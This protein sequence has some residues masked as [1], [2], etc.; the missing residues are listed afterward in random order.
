MMPAPGRPRPRS[1]FLRSLLPRLPFERQP[2]D[3]GVALLMVIM[4]MLVATALSVLLMGLVIA[5]RNPT[6]MQRKYAQTVHG[7]EAGIGAGLNQIRAATT[8]NA[9]GVSQGDRSKLPCGPLTG[10][11]GGESGNVGYQVAIAYFLTDPTA[12]SATWRSANALSCLAGYGPAQT[13]LYA[14]LTATGT[15]DAAP[16]LSASTGDRTLESVYNFNITN[17]NVAG[18]LIHNFYGG[19]GGNLDL[20]FD[21]GSGSPAADA[22]VT[23]TNCTIGRTSQLFSY[24][25]DYSLVLNASIT[26]SNPA[27]MCVTYDS[28]K[29]TL[30][31]RTC[32]STGTATVSQRWGFDASAH[33]RDPYPG[34]AVCILIQNDNTSGSPLIA[35]ST[36]C[37]QGYSRQWSWAPEPKVGAGNAG[38]NQSQLVNYQ[39]FG[40]CF[41]DTNWDLTYPYMIVWPCKQDPTAG[42]GWN[43]QQ[44]YNAATGQLVVNATS[45]VTA[46]AA[47]G[48]YVTLAPCVTG[49]PSQKWIESGN[50]GDYSSSY[51]IV[52]YQGRCLSL[53]PPN[54]A[55]SNTALHPWSTIVSAVC[56]GGTGQKWNAP[57]NLIDAANKN[58]RETTGQ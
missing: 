15:G 20:C 4:A 17:A 51:T 16:G 30:V 53:G 32:A 29:P 26:A 12:Q 6:I 8:A 33:F 50:T 9:L 44:T 48:G 46:P 43:Q 56:D 23:V 34:S 22:V 14:L 47:T 18:G 42:P 2:A 49:Q 58:T 28:S 5:Q 45:C 1:P 38:P 3:A 57:P 11:V 19:Q 36:T 40:R 10:T 25:T 21:A 39:Q 7:A 41:D 13:P 31:M 55:D 54:L 37:G 27:G 24:Q 35:N 52:D